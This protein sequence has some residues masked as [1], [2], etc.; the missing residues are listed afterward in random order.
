[1]GMTQSQK[2][3]ARH[4]DLATVAAGDLI[5][6]RLDLVLANDITGP[7][8]IEVFRQTGATRVFDPGRV[9]LTPSHFAPNKDIKSAE[10]CRLMRDFAA[11]E[12][13]EHYYEL[14]EE[15]AGIEHV[16]VP[17][18]G[19]A[20]PGDLIIGADS[21]TCTDGAL[22]AFATGV[23]STDLG[24][25]MATGSTWFRVP[26]ALAVELVGEPAPWITGKDVILELIRLIGVDG[27]LYASLEFQGEG[28][29]ALSMTDRLTI[30]NMG[31]EAGAKNAIMPA[32]QV[33][34]DWLRRHAPARHAASDFVIETA[35]PDARYRRRVRIDLSRLEPV[36]AWPSLPANG[37][38]IS[39]SAAE[40]VAIDQVVIGS[41]T[42]GRYADLALA[43]R[44]LRGRRVA[45]GL[46]CLVIPGAQSVWNRL[47]ADGLM[48]DFVAAG[49]IVSPPTCGPCL[50]GH[51]GVLAAGETCVSTTNRNFVGRM[52]HPESRVWLAGVPVAVA[53]AVTG[54]LT[55]PVE[56]ELDPA[57]FSELRAA[58]SGAG[59][60]GLMPAAKG[61]H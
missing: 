27:A 35:D 22:A 28:V 25:A 47:L 19:L 60:E 16:I 38:S 2:I 11:A 54:R 50:G 1:M 53:S 42:N 8:A 31:I 4:A 34:L 6:A 24:C 37:R 20:A 61:V 52:G 44:L 13:L 21:H 23:G 5:E 49:C 10:H 43:A 55:G 41:C 46:R 51:M 17:E 33:T 14:G 45:R 48:Q 58:T 39:A 32:D 30:C 36:V 40:N 26:D 15:R 12:T 18:L 7:P 57:A 59:L 56:A 3:L 9:L 29:A